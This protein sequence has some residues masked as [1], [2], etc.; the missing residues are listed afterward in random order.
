MKYAMVKQFSN[1]VVDNFFTF[2]FKWVDC[3]KMFLEFAWSFI[4]I[5]LAFFMIFYNVYMYIYYFFLFL[6]DRG[7]ETSAGYFRLRGT[8][9][10]VSY[11]PKIEITSAPRVS[12]P[13]YRA[14]TK[15]GTAVDSIM[16]KTAETAGVA[17]TSL[18]PQVSHKVRKSFLKRFLDAFG[19]ILIGLGRILT[20]PFKWFISLFGHGVE[21]RNLI[22][23]ASGETKSLIDEYMKEYEHKKK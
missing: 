22:K 12:H 4:E 20:W 18:K 14:T 11:M 13:M 16:K 23:T 5:W 3:A 8:Y 1:G 21:S 6:I 19:N 15:A 2:L 7:S 17:I 10:K 9:S